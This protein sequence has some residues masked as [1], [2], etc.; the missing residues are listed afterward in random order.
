MTS[1]FLIPLALLFLGRGKSKI[2]VKSL[3]L[4]NNLK[5]SCFGIEIIDKKEAYLKIDSLIIE[6]TKV[7][8]S[9]YDYLNVP[10]LF[11]FII[12]KLNL[13]C[14]T[15]MVNR[16]ITH[17]EKIVISLLFII[18]FNRLLSFVNNPDE[19]AKNFEFNVSKTILHIIGLDE[20]DKDDIDMINEEFKKTY[21]FP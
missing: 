17:K 19:Y 6:F 7:T 16:K 9:E 11:E 8:K 3:S 21:K 15:K 14:Y 4:A 12:K 13:V 20:D 1:L 5:F 18:I 10:D 2:P